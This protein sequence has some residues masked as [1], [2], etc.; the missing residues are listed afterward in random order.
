MAANLT[1]LVQE[2]RELGAEAI[3][4]TSLT[5]RTFNATTGRIQDTLLPWADATKQVAQEQSAHVLDLHAA[6]I[7]YVEAIGPDAAHRLNRLPEDNT[8]E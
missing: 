8:R 4:I 5:R 6:S 1:A 2:I 3:L 7:K